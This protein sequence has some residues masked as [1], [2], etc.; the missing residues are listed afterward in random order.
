MKG[1]V[2]HDTIDMPAARQ[3]IGGVDWRGRLA[4][5]RLALAPIIETS[6]RKARL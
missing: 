4:R 2:S 3:F 6:K 5:G 1:V